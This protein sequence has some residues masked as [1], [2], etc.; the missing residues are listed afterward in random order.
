MS[1]LLLSVESIWALVSFWAQFSDSHFLGRWELHGKYPLYDN[2][3]VKTWRG[4]DYWNQF[5]VKPQCNLVDPEGNGWEED[6]L[7]R[8]E[9]MRVPWHDIVRGAHGYIFFFNY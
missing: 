5:N 1:K 9:E 2:G 6:R 7:D 8:E 3:E 4:N